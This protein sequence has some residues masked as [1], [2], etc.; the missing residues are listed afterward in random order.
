LSALAEKTEAAPVRIVCI[1]AIGRTGSS[2]LV[3][4]LKACPQLNVKAELFK[5]NARLTTADRNALRTASGS[6]SEGG[7]LTKWRRSHPARVLDVLFEAGGAKPLFF[8]V[9]YRHLTREQI[10]NEIFSRDDIRYIVLRRRMIDSFI[11]NRKAHH[12][13]AHADVDTTGWKPTIQARE[14][15]AW[16]RRARSWYDWIA[17][18]LHSRRLPFLDVIYET[19]LANV[20]NRVA[21]ARILDGVAAM[22]LAG[23]ALP[24]KIDSFERQDR[25]SD[26]RA[27]VANWAEFEKEI[28]AVPAHAD[29]L[30]W[31]EALP[32]PIAS[33]PAAPEAAAEADRRS[34]TILDRRRSKREKR[35]A[36]KPTS[37]IGG[38]GADEGAAE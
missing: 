14:F 27:R 15:V 5:E 31:A 29:L 25:E 12:Y 37:E 17:Q 35:R 19:Q 34:G 22:G 13:G 1:L 16:T 24:R 20:E 8:K 6:A 11:S 10:S 26:Y 9:F 18:E 3:Q 36:G 2:H 21:L 28:A 33:A 38:R 32:A 4:L 7:A 23:I 30:R